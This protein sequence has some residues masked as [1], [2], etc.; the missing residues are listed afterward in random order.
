MSGY[1]YTDTQIHRYKYTDT[2]TDTDT[3]T[4]TYQPSNLQ[5]ATVSNR[6][7]EH[8]TCWPQR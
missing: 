6:N 3:D 5:K 4:V 8:A 7:I 1:G 2:D